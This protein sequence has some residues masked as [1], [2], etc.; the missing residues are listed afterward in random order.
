V[1]AAFGGKDGG[2]KNGSWNILM[3]IGEKWCCIAWRY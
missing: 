2:E 1:V 3:N